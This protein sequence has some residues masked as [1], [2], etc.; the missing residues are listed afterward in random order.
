MKKYVLIIL[1]FV[2]YKSN[3]QKA[4]IEQTVL[5][6]FMI[7]IFENDYSNFNDKIYFSGFTENNVTQFWF[8]KN[9][10]D[11]DLQLRGKIEESAKKYLNDN[12]VFKLNNSI[13][14]SKVKCKNSK[15]FTKYDIKVFKKNIVDD[16]TYVLIIFYKKKSFSNYYYF[17][18]DKNKTISR[19]CKTAYTH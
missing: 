6:Y 4:D 5:E 13:I 2:N 19:W 12:S 11:N 7:N 3:S 16:Y 10:F 8:R 18:V 15:L 1:V 14:K 17:E 9:C